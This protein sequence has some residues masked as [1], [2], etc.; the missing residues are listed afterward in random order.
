MVA[1][2]ILRG[3][4]SADEL[5]EARRESGTAAQRASQRPQ[6]SKDKGKGKGKGKGAFMGVLK[7]LEREVSSHKRAPPPHLDVQG[8]LC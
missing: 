1:V 2:V 6:G 8:C 5:E 3:F 7:G 4:L